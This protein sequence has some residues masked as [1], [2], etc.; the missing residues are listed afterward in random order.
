[1]PAAGPWA[2]PPPVPRLVPPTALETLAGG[3]PVTRVQGEAVAGFTAPAVKPF[4][5]PEI[6]TDASPTPAGRSGHLMVTAAFLGA[7][8]LGFA[9]F[10]GWRR[11]RLGWG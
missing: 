7:L 4:V 1:M 11:S 2:A 9:A 10:L 5:A 6:R 3:V 8:L